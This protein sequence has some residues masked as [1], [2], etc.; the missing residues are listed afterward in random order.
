[1][2]REKIHFVVYS[3]YGDK[4]LKEN[5]INFEERIIYSKNFKENWENHKIIL[6][7]EMNF[8]RDLVDIEKVWN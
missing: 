2:S 5:E 8:Y 4:N 7:E 6:I 3:N 1:M